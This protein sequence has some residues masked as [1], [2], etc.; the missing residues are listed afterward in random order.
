MLRRV[1]RVLLVQPSLSPPGG[2]NGVAA[3]MVQA[4]RDE[5]RVT[6]LCLEPPDLA[7]VNRHFGTSLRPADLEVVVAPLPRRGPFEL[8]LLRGHRLL[9][10]ARRRADRHD[11]L[12]TAN[13][14]GDLGRPGIQY[15][16][17]PKFLYPRPDAAP[18][19]YQR[20]D[21]AVRAYH[22]LA[23]AATGFSLARMRQNHTLVNSAWTGALVRKVHGIEAQVLH[24]P[25]VMAPSPVPWSEREDAFVC[26]GRIARDKRLEVAIDVIAR[27]RRRG[28]DVR[29]RLVGAPDDAEYLAE[30]TALARRHPFVSLHVGLARDDVARLVG[31]CRYGLHAMAE[32]HFG[33]AVAEL[34]R[35]GAIVFVP[36]GGGQREIVGD[37]E[38]LLYRSPDEAAERI[39]RVLG[40]AALR[41]DLRAHLAA[42]TAVLSTEVFTRGVRAAVAA[43]LG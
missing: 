6:L 30:V 15:V 34:A 33:M 16:H 17:F 18:R 23:A 5:H 41:E 43:R 28:F 10:A 13:N 22:R 9:A 20:S 14:E 32:E 25:V 35:S 1:P 3:W 4:L 11:V 27:V 42:R 37:D 7:A 36:R 12:V 29:L 19:W 21:A 39:G 24:P 38:R 2:G 8:A 31:R 26:L 40:D